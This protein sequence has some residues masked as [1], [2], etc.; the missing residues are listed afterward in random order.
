[1]GS[2]QKPN[3]PRPLTGTTGRL[4]A[5][6]PQGPIA[7]PIYTPALKQ[8]T[9]PRVEPLVTEG[10]KAQRRDIERRKRTASVERLRF[11]E[12]SIARSQ[13]VRKI[14]IWAVLSVLTVVGYRYLQSQYGNRW[15]LSVVWLAMALVLLGSLGWLVWYM[16]YD[17]L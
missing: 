13:Q 4:P 8:P 9:H 10:M 16:N 17:E 15:P 11:E 1:M 12:E 14:L 3:P 2:I 7:P 6:R 5:G